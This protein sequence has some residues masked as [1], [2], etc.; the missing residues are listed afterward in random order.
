MAIP[1]Q[2]KERGVS[3]CTTRLSGYH[4]DVIIVLALRCWSDVPRLSGV[5]STTPMFSAK[6]TTKA[7][8]YGFDFSILVLTIPLYSKCSKEKRYNNVR[9]CVNALSVEG[10]PPKWLLDFP[11]EVH[12]SSMVIRESVYKMQSSSHTT[13]ANFTTLDNNYGAGSD[14]QQLQSSIKT[15]Q[16]T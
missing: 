1:W 7:C 16:V 13:M 8:T 11:C 6:I 14:S 9:N 2:E 3:L 15:S 10:L 4:V 12:G 5:A